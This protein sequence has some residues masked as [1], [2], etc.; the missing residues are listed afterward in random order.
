LLA[1]L[2]LITG[3][4]SAPA[5]ADAFLHD[6][7]ARRRP[8]MVAL[9][10]KGPVELH[11]AIYRG[12][13]EKD[14]SVLSEGEPPGPTGGVVRATATGAEPTCKGALVM[15][16]PEGTRLF[17]VEARARTIEELAERLL[18]PLPRK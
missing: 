7:F 18:A 8:A 14:Y 9:E 16:S 15:L 4:A 13:I 5:P 2:L 6:E 1:A 12:L 11:E 17:E 10:A 3:C